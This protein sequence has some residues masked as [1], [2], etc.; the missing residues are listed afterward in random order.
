MSIV[1]QH[2]KNFRSLINQSE[3]NTNTARWCRRL[4]VTSNFWAMTCTLIPLEFVDLQNWVFRFWK[5]RRTVARVAVRPPRPHYAGGIWKRSFIS[6]ARPTVHTNP[7]RKR[8][9]SK[10]L[11]KPKEFENNGFSFSCGQDN[12]VI[13]LPDFFLSKHKS[14]M[15][16]FKFIRRRVDGKHLMRFQSETSAFKF[17]RQGVDRP[18]MKSNLAW[19]AVR[20]QSVSFRRKP[21]AKLRFTFLGIIMYLIAT[22]FS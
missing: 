17:L 10:T 20:W 3:K 1:G 8:S 18:L 22:C 5:S 12:Q 6:M 4:T 9:L 2:P 14:K 16:V 7:S 15:T 19:A 13:S 21:I 11:F